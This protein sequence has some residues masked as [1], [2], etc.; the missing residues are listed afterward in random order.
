MRFPEFCGAS[1]KAQSQLFCPEVTM[2]W[3]LEPAGSKASKSPAALFPIQGVRTFGTS[4]QVGG[5]GKF[6]LAGKL[7]GVQGNTFCEYDSLG[8]ETVIGTVEVDEWPA[9][10]T[11]DATSTQVLIASGNNGY[12]YN[13]FTGSFTLVRTGGTRVVAMLDGF[14][15]ALNVED[16]EFAYSTLY[17]FTAWDPTDVVPRSAA[18][19][20]WVAM[21]VAGST[22]WL[23]GTETCEPWYNAGGAVLPFAIHP[24]GV[25]PFGTAATFSATD[26]NGSAMWLGRTRYGVGGVVKV[27]GYTPENV[28]DF[29]LS[30]ALDEYEKIGALASCRAGG[31]YSEKGHLFVP[32]T[33]R[34]A[35][36]T[37]VFDAI[38]NKW[39]QRGTWDSATHSYDAW[40]PAFSAYVFNKH[41]FDDALG[42]GLYYLSD[43][44]FVDIGGGP[45]RYRRVARGPFLEEEPVDLRE[46]G[47]YIES[48]IAPSGVDAQCMLRLSGD[49]GRTWGGARFKSAGLTG[50][51]KARPRW[52]NLG[53]RRDPVFDLTITAGFAPRLIDAFIRVGEEPGVDGGP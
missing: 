35:R 29:A 9:S 19:D 41:V 6:A 25:Q 32:F 27:T 31:T 13:W 42:T 7:F 40:R 39:A 44:S 45:I 15:L 37:W 38:T 34:G 4:G 46:F 36:A 14:G 24:S 11:G 3:Y 8:N 48:G 16:N 26:V 50:D 18:P 12:C 33:F 28:A 49:G 51:Y 52:F 53:T 30:N 21:V 2:N 43:T 10:M 23:I 22:I 1:Y 20:P 5:R 47:I 17:D